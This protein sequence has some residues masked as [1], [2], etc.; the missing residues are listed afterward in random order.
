MEIG[1]PIV[2]AGVGECGMSIAVG[3]ARLMHDDPSE[4]LADVA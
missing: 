1:R 3:L 2:I 4:G